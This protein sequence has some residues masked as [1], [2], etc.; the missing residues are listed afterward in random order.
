MSLK[1]GDVIK[2]LRREREITQGELA[3]YLNMSPQAVSKW[4]TNMS[5]PDISLL[6]AIANFFGVSIDTLFSHNSVDSEWEIDDIYNKAERLYHDSDKSKAEDI[7][8]DGLQKYPAGYRLMGLLLEILCSYHGGKTDEILR[9]SNRILNDC[10]D[11]NIRFEVIRML[12][13]MYKGMG[14]IEKAKELISRYPKSMCAEDLLCVVLKGEEKAR[15]EQMILSRNMLRT[16]LAM[17][18]LALY[19]KSIGAYED[20]LYYI[21]T[22]EKFLDVFYEKGEY[23]KD[24]KL[25]DMLLIKATVYL[26]LHDIDNALVC[27]RDAMEH[28]VSNDSGPD[29]NITASRCFNMLEEN[30]PDDGYHC[31]QGMLDDLKKPCYD[32]IRSCGAFKE[33]ELQLEQK[34]GD[35]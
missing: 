11:D 27:L 31:C 25:I 29:H 16:F 3:E 24:S 30:T 19:S 10:T 5:L 15:Q 34:C 28:A 35:L 26:E 4:E 13:F 32:P 33:I 7:L 17:R 21:E 22:Y 12:A 14:N 2:R 20:A 8:R 6:P 23:D 1:I 9:I 18:A